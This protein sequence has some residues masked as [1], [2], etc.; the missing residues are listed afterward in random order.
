MGIP[1]SVAAVTWSVGPLFTAKNAG[2]AWQRY[3]QQM[4]LAVGFE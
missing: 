3:S 1:E 4:V 2:F